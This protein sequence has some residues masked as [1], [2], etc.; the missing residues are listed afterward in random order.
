MD[1]YQHHTLWSNYPPPRL[2]EI[3]PSF[4]GFPSFAVVLG[5]SEYHLYKRK[6]QH[7][8]A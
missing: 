7:H 3:G 6:P 5:L 4:Y 8:F 2:E 1:L